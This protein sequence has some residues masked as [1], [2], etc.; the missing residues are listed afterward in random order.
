MIIFTDAA[1]KKLANAVEPTDY[2]RVGVA[3]GGCAGLSYTIEVEETSKNEDF[4]FIIENINICMDPYS[5]FVLRETV[6]DYVE[7]LHQSG[8]KFNN[9]KATKSCGCGT[10]FK[11]E[12]T[13]EAP[14]EAAP[15]C[16]TAGCGS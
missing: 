13:S 1:I 7:S 16:L 8:F 6:V 2:I 14:G 15:A 10:S 11:P 9:S 12:K 4:I 3:K 5:K